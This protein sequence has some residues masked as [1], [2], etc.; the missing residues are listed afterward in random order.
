V[1]NNFLNSQKK[2]FIKNSNYVDEFYICPLFLTVIFY[3][4]SYSKLKRK[5]FKEK[6][7]NLKNRLQ[8]L[9]LVNYDGFVQCAQAGG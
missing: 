5:E 6:T 3:R 1:F 9:D 2:I 8:G 7:E 4:K